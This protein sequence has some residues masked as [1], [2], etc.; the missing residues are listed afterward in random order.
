MLSGQGASDQR[1][2]E[3]SVTPFDR[4]VPVDAY[5]GVT[6]HDAQVLEEIELLGD[7]IVIASATTRALSQ[8]DIDVALGLVTVPAHIPTPRPKGPGLTVPLQPQLG[9]THVMRSDRKRRD[10]R[11]DREGHQAPTLA[12]SPLAGSTDRTSVLV[13]GVA[14]CNGGRCAHEVDTQP[15]TRSSDGL[16]DET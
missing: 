5:D 9:S 3:V 13:A 12:E 10:R 7:L 15:T 8:R 6:L 2:D 1:A 11:R 16:L 14:E 4:S